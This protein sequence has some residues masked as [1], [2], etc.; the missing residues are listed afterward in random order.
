MCFVLWGYVL[1][2]YMYMCVTLEHKISCWGIF[3]ALY[4]SN[5]RF[6]FYDKIIK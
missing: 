4:G 2:Y 5:Y 3:V 6:F 1:T